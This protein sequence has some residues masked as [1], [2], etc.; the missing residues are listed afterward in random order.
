MPIH[1]LVDQNP[2]QNGSNVIPVWVKVKMAREYE[3]YPKSL[4]DFR[5]CQ[6]QEECNGQRFNALILNCKLPV[7][8]KA[9][10]GF[11]FVTADLPSANSSR[12]ASSGP[13]HQILYTR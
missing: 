1:E 10:I 2:Y 5:Q 4:F 11:R 3:S 13:V 9:G 12:D 7:Y 6:L 8:V